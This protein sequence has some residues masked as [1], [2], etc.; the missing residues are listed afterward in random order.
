[1]SV[2]KF[3]VILHPSD[4]SDVRE[5]F[6]LMRGLPKSWPEKITRKVPLLKTSIIRG[7]S[8]R[9]EIEGYFMYMALSG[10]QLLKLPENYC[11][12]RV[13][14]CGRMA[15]KKG[16]QLIGLG[17]MTSVIGKGGIDVAR[18][19][20]SAVTTGKTYRMAAVLEGAE[21]TIQRNGKNKE[22]TKCVIIG[23]DS[24][25]GSVCA[26]IL[27]R[28]GF[29]YITLISSEKRFLGN[30]TGK[31]LYDYGISVKITSN[32]NKALATADL[33]IRAGSTGH[34]KNHE[35]FVC[36]AGTIICDFFYARNGS[37]SPAWL[38]K[39]RDTVHI[40]NGAIQVSDKI[41]LMQGA[42]K[43]SHI[44]CADVAE[45]LLLA[46]E[47]RKHS[48]SLGDNMRVE[49]AEEIMG[50]ARKHGFV[51]TGYFSGGRMIPFKK[52]CE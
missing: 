16:V 5:K 20:N 40:E 33:V 34:E 26:H 49:K 1:M 44:A 14:K 28:K 24:A 19:L 7:K 3:A 23:A 11:L 48:Y 38:Y 32:V 41:Q 21:K 35:A 6:A 46:L 15:E 39:G 25:V 9:G 37:E 22:N 17:G 13:L 27:L 8:Q 51:Q 2:F 43:V 30:L 52:A 29:R 42:N 36:K 45:V 12:K 18:C 31:I 50:L 4:I 10:D 47:G